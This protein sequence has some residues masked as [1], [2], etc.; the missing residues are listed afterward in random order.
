VDTV[1]L[2]LAEP[3]PATDD[4]VA[5]QE[6]HAERAVRLMHRLGY[7]VVRISAPIPFNVPRLLAPEDGRPARQWQDQHHGSIQS[8]ADLAAFHWPTAE[9]IS[10]SALRAAAGALPAGMGLLGF[11]GGVLE[12]ATDLMGL[13]Q[14]MFAI[15]D[16]PDLV[17]GVLDGVGQTI[18]RVFE[19]YCRFDCV[20][21]LWLGDDL[22]SKN[23]L[24][25]GPDLLRERI[26]PWYR[27]FRELAHARGR[28]FLLH[29]CGNIAAVLPD[30]IEEVGI[31][32]KHSFEDTIQPVEEFQCRWGGKVAVLGGVDV[33]L[34]TRG[35][36][37]AI[38]AR[39]REILAC[40]APR[41][42]YVCGSG[43]SIPSYVPPDHYLA[44][45]EAVHEFNRS[46]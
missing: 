7:D 23:G 28:V 14:F 46:R 31:E 44:M 16:D 19:E 33:N 34:L 4:P 29:S 24:L 43:N 11:S 2:L 3:P 35:P 25:V 8:V 17:R 38:V 6:R 41:R 42:N 21:G 13:E 5:L 30:L 27:R 36:E 10:F 1:G 22:G 18:Y 9:D 45:L 32:A 12:F 15:H 40:A 20:C 39:T 37:S 26:F